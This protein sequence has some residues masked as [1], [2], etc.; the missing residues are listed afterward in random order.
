M[1]YL[2]DTKIAVEFD[3]IV[4]NTDYQLI[5]G[6]VQTSYNPDWKNIADVEDFTGEGQGGQIEEN[7]PFIIKDI[8]INANGDILVNGVDGQQVTIPGGKDTVITDSK[9]NTYNVDKDGNGSNVP[10]AA[11]EGGKPTPEY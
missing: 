3:N 5:R 9:G 11:A 4:V 7:V 6:V 10:V 2:A 8:V 1:P